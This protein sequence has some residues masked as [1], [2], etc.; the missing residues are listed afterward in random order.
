VRIELIHPT[1]NGACEAYARLRNSLR[2]RGRDWTVEDVRSEVYATILAACWH[3]QRSSSLRL[4]LALSPTASTFR[5]DLGDRQGVQSSEDPAGPILVFGPDQAY[6]ATCERELRNSFD[7]AR[8]VPVDRAAA[9]RLGREPTVDQVRALF[10]E[11]GLPLKSYQ[12]PDV[13][14]VIDR[15]FGW[16][17]SHL[18]AAVD[19]AL[20]RRLSTVFRGLPGTASV[21]RLVR[22]LPSYADGLVTLGAAAVF[23]VLT[24]QDVLGAGTNAVSGAILITLACFALTF[25]RDRAA[26]EK[27]V[28]KA[29][30]VRLVN[31][32]EVGVELEKA[33]RTSRVWTCKGVTGGHLRTV[34]LPRSVQQAQ[35]EGWGSLDVRLE[36]VDPTR[37]ALCEEYARFRGARMPSPGQRKEEWTAARVQVEA[38]ATVLAVCWHKRRFGPL[39]AD[40]ALSQVVCTLRWDVSVGHA[41]QSQE[42]PSAPSLVFTDE[43]PYYLA[44]Q[45]ELSF[46]FDQARRVPL[47]LAGNHP[48]GDEPTL[49]EVRKL[50]ELLGLKLPT[51]FRDN[52]VRAIIRKALAEP[53]ALG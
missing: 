15:S 1:E 31:G 30:A 11:L 48:L 29:A 5:W 52:D 22:R 47:D 39:R 26:R 17:R 6:Y 34:T 20:G 19:K 18:I 27:A 23:C 33:R 49:E 8:L 51:A 28:R 42:D 21:I 41:I 14:T 16:R 53:N 45:R 35:H 4:G 7:H 36:I 9:C 13:R 2:A 46:S 50:F 43:Q 25:M 37:P 32:P 10:E 12:D 3:M 38:Y 40:V 24:V 44:C